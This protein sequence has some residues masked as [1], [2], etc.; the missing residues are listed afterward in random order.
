MAKRQPRSKATAECPVPGRPAHIAPEAWA[1]RGDVA[2]T[3]K[4]SDAFIEGFFSDK[5]KP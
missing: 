2:R 4:R 5:E 1:S 3:K